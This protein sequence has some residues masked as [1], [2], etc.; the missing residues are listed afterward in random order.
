[1]EAEMK[2]YNDLVRINTKLKLLFSAVKVR[3]GTLTSQN[4]L[5][6]AMGVSP[7]SITLWFG[8]KQDYNRRRKFRWIESTSL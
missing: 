5:A 8:S 2:T 1:M 4:A 6:T 7:V 3:G